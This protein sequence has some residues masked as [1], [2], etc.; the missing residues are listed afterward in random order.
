MALRRQRLKRSCCGRLP[1]TH[2]MSGC[3]FLVD[4]KNLCF[5]IF[6][7]VNAPLGAVFPLSTRLRRASRPAYSCISTLIYFHLPTTFAATALAFCYPVES[8]TLSS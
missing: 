4:R 3:P 7:C 2:T 8:A 6:V 5:N 1:A